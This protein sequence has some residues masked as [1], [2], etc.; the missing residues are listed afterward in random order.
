MK[1]ETDTLTG[2]ELDYEVAK[3]SGLRDVRIRNNTVEHM[4]LSPDLP[5]QYLTKHNP[6][7]PDGHEYHEHRGLAF[8]VDWAFIGPAIVEIGGINLH[9]QEVWDLD[10][11]DKKE[12]MAEWGIHN[13]ESR[14]S[15]ALEAIKRCL[16]KR[17][18]AEKQRSQQ[19]SNS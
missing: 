13:D 4:R 9:E 3:A 16:V 2:I 17:A 5:E 15:T 14:G 1:T 11:L 7:F 19:N 12:W 10:D 6:L 18:S 8:E